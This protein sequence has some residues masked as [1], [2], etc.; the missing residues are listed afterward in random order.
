MADTAAQH[1]EVKNSVVKRHFVLQVQNSPYDVADTPG[2]QPV[3][4]G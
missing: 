3:K 4:S 2:Q 1:K